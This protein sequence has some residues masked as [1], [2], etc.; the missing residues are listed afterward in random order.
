MASTWVGQA[1]WLTLKRSCFE[2]SSGEKG[3]PWGDLGTDCQGQELSLVELDT[4]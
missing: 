4:G 3:Q 2:L 1:G